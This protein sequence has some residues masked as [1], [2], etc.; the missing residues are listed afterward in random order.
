MSDLP[1]PGHLP[2]GS[3]AGVTMGKGNLWAKTKMFL[4]PTEEGNSYFLGKSLWSR[5][6]PRIPSLWSP[7]RADPCSS[8]LFHRGLPSHLRQGSVQHG[9]PTSHVLE[10]TS[11][12]SRGFRELPS[13]NIIIIKI[14]PAAVSRKFTKVIFLICT[15]S[16]KPQSNL[17]R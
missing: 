8:W 4:L 9:S 15:I 10:P 6:F 12:G 3:R 13:T 1:L 5:I 7:F 11:C 17:V 16:I 2:A 14:I